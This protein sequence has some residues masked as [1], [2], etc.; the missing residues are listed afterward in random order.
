MPASIADIKQEASPADLHGFSLRL[1][2]RS[3]HAGVGLHRAWEVLQ[4]LPSLAVELSGL[5]MAAS[6]C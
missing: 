2:S 4:Y 3:R 5:A 6:V 1:Y